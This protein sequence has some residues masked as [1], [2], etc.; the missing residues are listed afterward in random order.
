MFGVPKL[1]LDAMEGELIEMLPALIEASEVDVG[2]PK[3]QFEDVDQSALL[4]EVQ[5]SIFDPAIN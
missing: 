4:A 2:V 5:L 3:D 1:K